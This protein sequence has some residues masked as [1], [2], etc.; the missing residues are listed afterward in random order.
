MKLKDLLFYDNIV[1]Q[2][3]DYPDADSIAAGFA[4][5]TYLKD[6]NKAVSLIYSG[7][8]EITK[9]NLQILINELNIPIEYVTETDREAELIVTVDCVYTEKN[10]SV[11]P[12]KKYASIDH[13]HISGEINELVEIRSNYGSCSSVLAKML[14]EDGVSFNKYPQA[15]TALYYGLYTDTNGFSEISHPADKDLRDF[16]VYDIQLLRKLKNSNITLEEL[17]IAGESFKNVYHDIKRKF[18]IAE[19]MPC[20]PNILGLISDILIQVKDVEVCV[21]FSNATEHGIKYSVRSFTKDMKAD[22]LAITISEGFGN[23]GGHSLKAGGFLSNEALADK[24]KKEFFIERII[25]AFNN[26]RI[27]YSGE[28][29]LSHLELKNYRR[30]RRE[31]GFAV[32]TDII[33]SGG[34]L[35]IRTLLSDCNITSDEDTFI[36]ISESGNV[37]P[38]EKQR[39]DTMYAAAEEPFIFKEEPEYLPQ[40]IGTGAGS[41]IKFAK[42]CTAKEEKNVFAHQLTENIKLYTKWDHKNYIVGNT[43]D[44]IV[45]AENDKSDIY[46]VA[47]KHF[48][49]NYEQI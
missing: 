8:K 14:E 30:L 24:D 23:G 11:L 7:R 13:H 44:Y 39:F 41:L 9:P 18:A 5:Y 49:E 35:C 46:I 43:G 48:E 45:A 26:Y 1:I 47:K 21:V 33:P 22:E 10:I 3:H 6:K 16:A 27:V 12:A 40:I 15:A 28:L 17:S 25:K 37:H 32:S 31:C 29:N 38:I 42:K 2:C 19:A 36:I 34:K 4:L 20:D